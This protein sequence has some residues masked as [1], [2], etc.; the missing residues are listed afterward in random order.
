MLAQAPCLPLAPT[1]APV[2]TH[3]LCL[4]C[5]RVAAPLAVCCSWLSRE[6]C[7]TCNATNVQ[8]ED[9]L[10]SVSCAGVIWM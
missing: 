7:C 6:S 10:L 8:T 5:R 2:C 1:T 9:R 3:V 4:V